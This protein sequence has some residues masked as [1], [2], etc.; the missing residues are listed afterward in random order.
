MIE[1]DQRIEDLDYAPNPISMLRDLTEARE[2]ML[3]EACE[4]VYPG[5]AA[6]AESLLAWQAT[7]GREPQADSEDPDELEMS[8]LQERFAEFQTDTFPAR[9]TSSPAESGTTTIR[10]EMPFR[11]WHLDTL[12]INAAPDYSIM[13][14]SQSR[15]WIEDHTVVDDDD[16]YEREWDEWN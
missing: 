14:P 16:E 6:R 3:K 1:S 15:K 12:L 9:I 13:T 7:N 11:F 5:I 8:R 10:S 2:A 4:T